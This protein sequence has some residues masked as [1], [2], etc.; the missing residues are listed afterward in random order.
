MNLV[1]KNLN[2][3]IQIDYCNRYKL[4]PHDRIHLIWY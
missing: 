4:W 2:E 1:N 3:K